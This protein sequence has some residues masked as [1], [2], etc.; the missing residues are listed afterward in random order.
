M[1]EI[2]ID[3]TYKVHLPKELINLLKIK[4]KDRFNIHIEAG[5]KIVM[6]KVKRNLKRD[7]KG[8]D[9]LIELLDS[10]AH[11]DPARLKQIKLNALE[12]KLWTT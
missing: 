3:D 9:T 4:P 6:E 10:P 5:N 12:E 2:T 8:K 7:E 11:V 1:E